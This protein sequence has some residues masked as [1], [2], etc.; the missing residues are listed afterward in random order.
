MTLLAL[1]NL[2][3]NVVWR[4][5]DGPLPFSI[6]FELGRETEVTNFDFHFVIQE[7]VTDFEISVNDPVRVEVLHSVANLEHIALNLKLNKSLSPPEKLVQRLTLTQ[8]QQN[9]DVLSIFEEVLEPNNMLVVQGPMDLDL[10]HQFLFGPRFR[11]GGL[12]NYLGSGHF[13]SLRICELVALGKTTLSQELASNVLLYANV[14]IEADYLL[15]DNDRIA[16]IVHHI[17][18]S[19]GLLALGSR[20]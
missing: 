15:F 6:K 20:H 2:R 7:Q 13:A 5:A 17:A 19:P 9:I 1:Q 11:Q 10:T 8:L 3:S 14:A 16:L 12:I 4:T 18:F